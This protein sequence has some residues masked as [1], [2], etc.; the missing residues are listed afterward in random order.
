MAER[1][2][3]EADAGSDMNAYSKIHLNARRHC[4]LKE[5]ALFSALNALSTVTDT[6][7]KYVLNSVNLLMSVMDVEISAAIIFS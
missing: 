1:N 7:L 2:L 5:Y 3:P 6:S 4:A